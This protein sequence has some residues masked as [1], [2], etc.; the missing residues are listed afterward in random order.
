L[1]DIGGGIVITPLLVKFR[2][3]EQRLAHGNSLLPQVFVGLT[4]AIPYSLKGSIDLTASFR[5]APAVVFTGIRYLMEKS[6]E[7]A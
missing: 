4:G 7:K 2:N 5:I 6:Q 3:L 1:L